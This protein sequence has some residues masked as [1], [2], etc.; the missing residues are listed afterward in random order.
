[1]QRFARIFILSIVALSWTT[2]CGST[3]QQAEQDT[4]KASKEPVLTYPETRRDAIVEK[5]HGVKVADPYRWLEDVEDKRVQAW[6][7]AQDQ[8]ARGYLG[9]LPNR[10]E[11][12]ERFA[13]LYYVDSIS[14]PNRRGENYFYSRRHADKEKRVYYWR[15]G[16]DGK[17]NVLLDPNTLSDDGSI[18][19]GFVR[20]SWDGKKVA[21]SLKEN[22]ADEATLYVMETES[23]KVSDIDVIDGMKYGRPAWTPESD[24]FYYTYLPTD[25]SIPV[26]ERPGYAEIRFH[27]LGEDPADDRLVREKTGDPKIFAGVDLSRDGKYL[28]YFNWHGWTASDIY[29][30][31][32]SRGDEEFKPLV[33]GNEARY[34][35]EVHDGHFYIS[36]NEGAPR[37][38]VFKV[39][40][41]NPARENWKEIIAEYEDRAVIEEVQITGGR[42][43]VTLTRNV[44]S[45]I[46]VYDLEGTLLRDI[47]LPGVGASFGMTGNPEDDTAYFSFQSPTMPLRIYKTSIESGTT[48]L[49]ATSIRS[50]PRWR[51]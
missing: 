33:V 27:K 11:L 7:D 12:A 46:H 38:R 8:V 35:V 37:Y 32:L 16:E 30:R 26:A 40:A 29:Y 10:D 36:T 1:M 20:P 49:W 44:Q 48:S 42:L 45:D 50:T 47:E 3:K 22:N 17:E 15:K 39:D 25:P 14:A 5:I 34:G 31:D 51:R 4:E 28:F 13:E 23:G 6:M 19:V 18:S 43:V 2:A 41:G 21:Y 9:D 24:G